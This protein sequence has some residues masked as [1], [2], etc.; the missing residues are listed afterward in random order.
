MYRISSYERVY[1]SDSENVLSK[2]SEF[3]TVLD[4]RDFYGVTLPRNIE[5]FFAAARSFVVVIYE[6][7]RAICARL[8]A[9]LYGKLRARNV[10]VR[11]TI[12]KYVNT[13]DTR[14]SYSAN[15]RVNRRNGSNAYAGDATSVTI[16]RVLVS[17]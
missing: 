1:L 15:F 9:Q 10:P 5:L 14:G 11:V 17:E 7:T 12:R 4:T 6:I 3:R 13:Y 8:C 2:V 16:I